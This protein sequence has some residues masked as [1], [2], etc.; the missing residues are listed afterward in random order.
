MAL[1]DE[2]DADADAGAG[3]RGRRAV[4]AWSGPAIRDMAGSGIGDAGH[5]RRALPGGR[6]SAHDLPPH[7]H[8]PGRVGRA[9]AG[10][11]L[12]LVPARRGRDRR[13]HRD[14]APPRYVLRGPAR[15][16]LASGPG[17]TVSPCR[18]R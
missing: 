11:G 18:S 4:A 17:M 5:G 6:S 10:Y 1:V 13:A 15:G 16:P 12:V 7:G 9:L 3:A 8:Q 14:A 2:P